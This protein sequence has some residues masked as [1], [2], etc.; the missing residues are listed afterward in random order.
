VKFE[1]NMLRL[2]ER[3]TGGKRRLLT[4]CN[5]VLRGELTPSTPARM[6]QAGVPVAGRRK[7]LRR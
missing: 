2:F 3:L 7:D 1:S 6:T 5:T 4:V